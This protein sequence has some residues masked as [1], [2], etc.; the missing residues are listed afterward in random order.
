MVKVL[1]KLSKQDILCILAAV[2]FIA[3]QVWLDLRMPD[4]MTEITQ[5][6]QTEGS[7]MSAILTA[8][9]KMLL[10]ALGSLLSAVVVSVLAARI[11][12]DFGADLRGLLFD[13]VQS[14]SMAEVGQFSTSSLITRT[15]N[16]VMQVQML[17]IMGLQ[18]LIKAPLMAG[19]A[20]IKIADKS[21]EWTLTTTAA[22]AILLVIVIVAIVVVLPKF[23]KLQQLTDDMNRVTR[24][25]LTGIRVVR[26]YNAEAYQEAKFTEA[27]N[28][29]TDTHLFTGRAM[30]FMM[31]SIQLVMNGLS[32]AIYLIGAM[33]IEKAAMTDKLVLFSDM[34]VFTQYAMQVVMAFMLLVM[35]FILY[36]RAAVSA[37]RISEVLDMPLSIKDGT[38]SDTGM[39]HI[40]EIEFRNVSFRYPGAEED[41]LSGI[42]FSAKKGETVAIIGSTGSGKSTLINLIPR[43][44]D[45]TEGEV[46]VA[47]VNVREYSQHA[48][49]DKIGYVSQKATLF[50]GTVRDNIAFGDS[51]KSLDHH[52]VD[53]AYTAQAAEFIDKMSEGYNSHIAQGG[54]NL[55]GGQKQRLSIARA[56]CRNPEI[57]IF[58]DSFSALDYKTDRT[59]R[60]QLNEDHAGATKVIVAQRIGTIRDADRILV[61]DDGRLVGNGMHSDLMQNCEVYRQ[62]AYSQ[63]SEEELA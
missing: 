19:W 21:T 9:G 8:G 2:V 54:G 20:I 53:A 50:S 60:K 11:A 23:K 1:K 32:L 33:L 49:R 43:F 34:I 44:Y 55:S 63:L 61:L 39:T 28:N 35:L 57:L 4:Y 51:S 59:L 7:E 26:A 12:T 24:E 10:C 52:C 6:V 38:V 40:G 14:F 5:L 56:L 3:A 13:K 37:K 25:N 30:A 17:I 58:D 27:N 41:M 15:T 22:V 31:P 42:S 62:I 46:L 18:S 45:V 48:L 29:L 36:P 47:G 16:D